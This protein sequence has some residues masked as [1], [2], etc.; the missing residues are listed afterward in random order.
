[1]Q[2]V[3]SSI[4]QRVTSGKIWKPKVVVYG[5]KCVNCRSDRGSLEQIFATTSAAG[6]ALLVPAGKQQKQI[7]SNF[8]I[9]PDP[10]MSDLEDA[11]LLLELLSLTVNTVK[12]FTPYASQTHI[13]IHF[14]KAHDP[15]YPLTLP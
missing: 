2:L 9:F 14:P 3:L 4:S 7:E 5:T 13:T 11:L 12:L 6:N 15:Y 10:Y 8:V 1:M